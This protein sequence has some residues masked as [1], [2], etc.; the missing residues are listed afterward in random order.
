[1]L[2]RRNTLRVALL[3]M[4]F[5]ALAAT[6]AL[7]ADRSCVRKGE[8]IYAQGDRMV[9]VAK[10]IRSASLE[11]TPGS[12]TIYACSL[13]HR[14]RVSVGAVGRSQ[15][16]NFTLSHLHGNA[17]YAAFVTNGRGLRGVRVFGLSG[18]SI[19]GEH[20]PLSYSPSTD[21]EITSMALSADGLIGWI[22]VDRSAQGITALQVREARVWEGARVVAEDLNIDPYLLRYSEGNLLGWSPITRTMEVQSRTPASAPTRKAGSCL[23]KGES[24]TYSNSGVIV[25][26]KRIRKTGWD[27]A[28]KLTACS[29]RFHRRVAIGTFGERDSHRYGATGIQANTRFIAFAKEDV[30]MDGPSDWT[31]TGYDL[32]TGKL[33]IK[34]P[35]GS[36]RLKVDEHGNIAWI[37]YYGPPRGGGWFTLN[38][39]D[40]RG[41]TKL[42]DTGTGQFMDPFFMAFE[43]VAGETK[44]HYAITAAYNR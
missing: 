42:V 7:A 11:W 18:G 8:R 36:P 20:A 9:Y 32:A 14:Q 10:P 2:V 30:Q 38:L 23:R 22:A 24:V 21:A 28:N 12:E 27:G 29:T 5:V 19:M 34:R 37:T 15:G 17:D 4:L 33:I 25:A 41:V 39:F 16:R 44:L 3:T 31:V 43:D 40:A 13:V 1:M 6:N 35:G 26:K